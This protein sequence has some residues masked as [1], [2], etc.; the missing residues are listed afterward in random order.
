MDLFQ[1]T[2]FIEVAHKKS[3]TKASKS[4]HISQPSIS[5]GIKALE[6]HWGV[7]L[8]DRKGKNVELT[9]TGSYLLPKIEELI[10]GFTQLNEEMESPQLLNSGKLSVGVPPMIGSSVIA[11]FIAHFINT[12]PKIELEMKEVGSQDVVSAID[13]GLIQVGFV[14]LP[15]TT[16]IPYEFFI[17]HEEPLDV[18]LWPD[19][20]LASRPSL[21]LS[22]IKDETFVFYPNGFSLNPYLRSAFQEI[23]AHPKIVCRSSNWDFLA[24]MVSNWA[25]PSC[26]T[27]FVSAFRRILPY[28]FPWSN[29]TCTGRWPSSGKA[30]DTSPIRPGLG[31]SPLKSI[32]KMP[33]R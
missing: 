8:F 27:P 5:K 29:L 21:T 26:R 6:E 12:Y 15:I 7:Q 31:S 11:P 23:M 13:D 33:V 25:F 24:Q 2:Y 4:L 10:K 1:L 17:F 14:A 20:P 32:S 28:P 3:F 30:R 18:V 22:D 9:E 16:E 19:H